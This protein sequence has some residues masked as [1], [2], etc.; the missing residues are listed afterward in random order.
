MILGVGLAV[1]VRSDREPQGGD[2]VV[3]API[4]GAAALT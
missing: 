4:P 1:F 3:G 2:A